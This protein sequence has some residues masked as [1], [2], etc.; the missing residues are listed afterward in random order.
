MPA[1]MPTRRIRRVC[2]A[3]PYRTQASAG[4]VTT[5]TGHNEPAHR[6]SARRPGVACSKALREHTDTVK[7]GGD[8]RCR[9]QIMADTL[10]EPL[11]GQAH[12]QDVN[13]EVQIV[14]PWTPCSM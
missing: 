9:D 3:G 6:V 10:V 7:A 14:I 5:G 8:P 4:R 11:T 12:A 2:G 13:A 1:G